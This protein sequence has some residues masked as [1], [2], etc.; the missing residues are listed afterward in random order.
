MIVISIFFTF[1]GNQHKPSNYN[2]HLNKKVQ[3][4]A[5]STDKGQTDSLTQQKTIQ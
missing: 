5:L 1:R 2:Y 4:F 3:V